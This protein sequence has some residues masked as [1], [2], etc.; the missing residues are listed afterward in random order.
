MHSGTMP[1]SLS[2]PSRTPSSAPQPGPSGQGGSS[3]PPEKP[4]SDGT[5]LRSLSPVGLAAG[6]AA[7]ATASV[8]GGQLGVAGTV[9]GAFLTSIVSATALAVYSESVKRGKRAVVKIKDH[10]LAHVSDGTASSGA[11]D[12]SGTAATDPAADEGADAG[13]PWTRTRVLKIVLGALAIAAIAVVIVFGIQ[14]ATGTELSTGTGTIQ[15][16]VSGEDSVVP[17]Q[18]GDGSTTPVEDPTSS[19]S[20]RESSSSG[21]PTED[22]TSSSSTPSSSGSATRTGQATAPTSAPATSGGGRGG[23]STPASTGGAGSQGGRTQAPQNGSGQN[24]GGQ[25]QGGQNQ[26]QNQGA[27]SAPATQSGVN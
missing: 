4:S 8:V 17:R 1:E 5:G 10:A 16:S 21:T 14:R 22:A 2:D 26:G 20:P 27:A 15:R 13:S 3:A 24:Q 25:N 6:G 19:T 7:A 18:G 9:I 23:A 12:A 11:A